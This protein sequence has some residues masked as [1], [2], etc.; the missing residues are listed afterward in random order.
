[1]YLRTSEGLGE[2]STD[3]HVTLLVA[4]STQG[5]GTTK[6]FREAWF[7]INKAFLKTGKIWTADL[8][9]DDFCKAR[10]LE[11]NITGVGVKRFA[12][13][14][15]FPVL[16]EE[17]QNKGPLLIDIGN[18]GSKFV[19]TLE[20]KGRAV[21]PPS[22]CKPSPPSPPPPVPVK[23]P[24][25]S[26]VYFSP[27]GSYKI[28]AGDE[29]KILNWYS[30]LPSPTQIK[31]KSGKLPIVVEGYASTTQPA[32]KNKELS[33]KR[34]HQVIHILKKIAGAS[35]KFVVYP[36]GESKALTRDEV[37][38]PTERRVKISVTDN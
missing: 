1:M 12:V 23:K 8:F 34:A 29:A 20:K 33:D 26:T 9:R 30:R 24:Y 16:Y 27:P 36:Y 21:N 2:P 35:A 4:F 25:E 28:Q 31:I 22:P 32:H 19:S 6:D 10:H 5:F 37:E 18:R 17:R 11:L 3:V 15:G 14:R 7:A 38:D 13:V